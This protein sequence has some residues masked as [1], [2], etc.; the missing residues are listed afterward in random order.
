MDVNRDWTKY[1]RSYSGYWGAHGVITDGTV[2][3]WIYI[4]NIYVAAA[5]RVE[6]LVEAIRIAPQSLYGA[7]ELHG[8]QQTQNSGTKR[9]MSPN[10]F[11]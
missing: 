9:P 6:N 10:L 5:T 3:F 2:F 4:P 8:L 11:R 1:F 7:E